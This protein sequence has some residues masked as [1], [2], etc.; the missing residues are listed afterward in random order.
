MTERDSPP[1]A[2]P[3]D[4]ARAKRSR[5]GGSPRTAARIA[6]VQAL[7]QIEMSSAAP[8]AVIGEFRDHR[9]AEQG[10]GPAADVGL[11]STLTAAASVHRG[12]IDQLIQGALAE[13]WALGRLDTVVR[14][15]LRAGV[16]ELLEFADVPARVVIDQYLD[17]AHAFL[18]A[19]ET[20][21]V[22]G[23]L[24]RL[25]RQLRPQELGAAGAPDAAKAKR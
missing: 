19:K 23:V 13:G 18:A 12:E 1:P 4:A 24:D 8:D 22:N 17:V 10:E 2:A 16:C 9:L 3:P 7:Y 20:G 5:A 11:F 6:A 21:F 15:L 25:A 14:A